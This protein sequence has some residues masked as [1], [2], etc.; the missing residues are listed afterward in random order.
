MSTLVHENRLG[1]C[2]VTAAKNLIQ[3][4]EREVMVTP[5]DYLDAADLFDGRPPTIED[6]VQLLVDHANDTTDAGYY[7]IDGEWNLH[8]A[9]PDDDD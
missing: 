8:L 1:K 4:M 2:N 7:S 9:E 5:L 6:Y 3:Y